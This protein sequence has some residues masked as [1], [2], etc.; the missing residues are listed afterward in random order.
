MDDHEFLTAFEACK[1]RRKDWTHEAHV[2]VAWLYLTRLPF[3]A[4]RDLVRTGIPKLNAEFRRR[5]LLG[6]ASRPTNPARKP[7][8]YHATITVAFATLIA[9][10]LRPG[11]DFAAFREH[12]PDLFDRTLAALLRHYSPQRLFS[13]EAAR[14]FLGPDLQPLPQL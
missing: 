2:R 4:A 7:T 9:S 6:C 5:D 10:R 12:N 11:Q 8:G 13:A 14:E 1:L 3:P